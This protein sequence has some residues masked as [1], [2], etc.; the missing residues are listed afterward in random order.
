MLD[1][2]ENA[3]PGGVLLIGVAN[4]VSVANRTGLPP[5]QPPAN[6]VP[7][8]SYGSTYYVLD[9]AGAIPGPFTAAGPVHRREAIRCSCLPASAER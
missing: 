8:F 1:S 4:L 3:G 5:T 2:I 6:G 7:F 9:A